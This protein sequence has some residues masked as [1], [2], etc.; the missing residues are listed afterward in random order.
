MAHWSAKKHPRYMAGPRKGQ[1]KDKA[2]QKKG[3]KKGT[4]K[5]GKKKA[6]KKTSKPKKAKKSKAPKGKI[7]ATA[8]KLKASGIVI[9]EGKLAFFDGDK[10]LR[11]ST[12]R[13]GGRRG[14]R[15]NCRRVC[16]T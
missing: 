16:T 8:A 3:A 15:P 12:R 13:S 5:T 11:V 1:F 10:N 14:K 9:P 6:S 2:G 4:K 7:L